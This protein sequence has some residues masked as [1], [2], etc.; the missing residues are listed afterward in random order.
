MFE[1]TGR[2]IKNFAYT[3]F[4]LGVIAAIIIGCYIMN[5]SPNSGGFV[6]MIATIIGSWFFSLLLYGF[7]KLIENSDAIVKLIEKNS[8]KD[9][10]NTEEANQE[11]KE[12]SELV[13]SLEKQ[14]EDVEEFILYAE[15]G[16]FIVCKKEEVEEE[17]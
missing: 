7:G 1:N 6:I 16:E 9:E 15:D 3:F 4:V 11:E 10:E 14:P 2:K 5:N 12:I 8:S 13:N 17:L